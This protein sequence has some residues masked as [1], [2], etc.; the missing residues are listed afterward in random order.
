MKF[1][2]S[3]IFISNSSIISKFTD[4][5]DEREFIFDEK[6]LCNILLFSYEKIQN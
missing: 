6:R 5:I 2:S 3:E 4:E 1:Q